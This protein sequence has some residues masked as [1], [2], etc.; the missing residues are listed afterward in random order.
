MTKVGRALRIGLVGAVVVVL[1][2]AV[3]SLGGTRDPGA[4]RHHRHQ[5]VQ[6]PE[7]RPPDALPATGAYVHTRVLE[8]GVLDVDQWLR[9][10]A[11]VRE[12][13]LGADPIPGPGGPP[14]ATFVRVAADGEAVTGPDAVGIQPRT[15]HL[16]GPTRLVHVS[17]LLT[18]VVV[19]EE[20]GA[21]DPVAVMTSLGVDHSGRQGTLRESVSGDVRQLHC[22]PRPATVAAARPCGHRQG[23]DWRVWLT[24][25]Q[26]DTQVAAQLGSQ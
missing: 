14:V 15:V 22:W 26:R 21:G 3:N 19:R 18:G 20:P 1:A 10:R 12:V 7:P 2:S 4:H 9:T 8:S 17:Y 13:T 6:A 16:G 11:P 23:D 25:S 5:Q 24:E